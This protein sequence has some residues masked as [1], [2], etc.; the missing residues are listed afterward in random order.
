MNKKGQTL[1]AFVII[2]PVF[3]LLLAFLVDTGIILKEKTK[4]KNTI[5][6][7]L[8]NTN[9][10]ENLEAYKNKI[11][12]LLQENNLNLDYIQIKQEGENIKITNE[13]SKESVFGTIIGIKEYKIKLEVTYNTKTK[14]LK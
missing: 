5:S 9:L 1:I 6:T 8:K 12:K 13:S 11:T 7:V 10:E 14:T 3:I 2:I 4:V